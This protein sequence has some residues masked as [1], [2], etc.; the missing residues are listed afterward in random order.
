MIHKSV[1]LERPKAAGI[2]MAKLQSDMNSEP[3]GMLSDMAAEVVEGRIS[4]DAL[5]KK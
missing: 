5:N 2:G 4:L 1:P 3:K